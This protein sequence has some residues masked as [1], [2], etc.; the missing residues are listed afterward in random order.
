MSATSS[1]SLTVTPNPAQPNQPVVITASVSGQNGGGLP[2]GTV[3]FT[4]NGT[5]IGVASLLNGVAT[6]TTTLSPGSQNI[7]A[8][9][10]G[11]SI[12]PSAS[13]N[14]GVTVTKPGATTTFS[15][16]LTSTVFGQSV[17]LTVRFTGAQGGSA[18][19]TG[20]VQFLDNGV[21]IGSPVTIVNG[22]AT[23]TIASLPPGTNNIG[24]TYNG[25]GNFSS[26]T[27]NVGTVTVLQGQVT[28]T[29]T[30]TTS[31]NQMTLTATVAVTAPGAGTPTG[32]VQFVDS[33]TGAVLGTATLSSTGVA[34]ITIPVTSDPIV[35]VYSGDKLPHQHLGQFGDHSHNRCR[36]LRHNL[37][38]G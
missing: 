1:I 36:R 14:I 13:T 32:T 37:L 28:T 9:Y 11:D 30:S 16:N 6:L 34:T 3:S 38:G 21:P 5:V 2:S 12:Y 31:G 4:D 25:D 23:L 27:K 8:T 20:T 24:V 19:P 33:R 22:V 7:G 35:A 17:T 15:S 10:S 29:L 18:L 26:L